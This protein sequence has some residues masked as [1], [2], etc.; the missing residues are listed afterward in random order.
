MPVSHFRPEETAGQYFSSRPMQPVGFRSESHAIHKDRTSEMERSTGTG[1]TAVSTID[2]DQLYA[3]FTPLVRRLIR[4]YGDNPEI[5]NDMEGEIYYR[6]CVLVKAYDPSRGV[7]LRPYL[8]RQLSASI[9]TY[10]RHYWRRQSREVSLELF[11]PSSGPLTQEDPTRDWDDAIELQQT[12]LSLPNAIAKLSAR[13]RNVVVWRYFDDLS[14]EE[15][16][17]RLAVQTSTARSL[18]RHALNHLRRSMKST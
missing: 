11:T 9:Y 16:A 15:I 6:F 3:E 13:Q 17:T 4:Q 18:L 7:P 1:D 2:P 10:A 5:R 14:F 8:V 12:K